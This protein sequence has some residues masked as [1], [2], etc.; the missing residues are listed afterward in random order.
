MV[1]DGR[2]VIAEL[3]TEGG[4]LTTRQREWQLWLRLT[5]R[6]D[7]KEWRPSDWSEIEEVLR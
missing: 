4:R 2:L 5:T 6:I 7:V 3:K 1:R